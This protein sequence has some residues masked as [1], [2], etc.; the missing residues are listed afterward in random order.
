MTV[1]NRQCHLGVPNV[2][3]AILMNIDCTTYY[4]NISADQIMM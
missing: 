1:Y 3:C 4:N 2:N